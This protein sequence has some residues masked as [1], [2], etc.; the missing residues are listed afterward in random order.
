MDRLNILNKPGMLT[1]EDRK[2]PFEQGC[3]HFSFKTCLDLSE[4]VV[5]TPYGNRDTASIV[6]YSQDLASFITYWKHF[7]MEDLNGFSGFGSVDF[8][9]PEGFK[10]V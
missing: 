5:V 1:D 9:F 4:P 7:V 10:L 2:K 6:H 3:S 8:V